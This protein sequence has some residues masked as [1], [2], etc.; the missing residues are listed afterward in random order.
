MKTISDILQYMLSQGDVLRAVYAVA[1]ALLIM[2]LWKLRL[3]G[4]DVVKLVRRYVLRVSWGNAWKLV[5]LT[6]IIW[7]A[8]GPFVSALQYVEQRWLRPVYVN[9]YH[10]FDA[11]VLTKMY[12]TEIAEHVTPLQL[13]TIRWWTKRT[14]TRIGCTPLE[15]YETAYFE[16]GG[17][18]FN[19][20]NPIAAGWI[21]FTTNGIKSH[22]VTLSQV[23]AACKARYV[24]PIMRLTDEYLYRR[25]QN[26]GKPLVTRMDVYMAIFSPAFIGCR[27]PEQVIYQGRDNPAYYKNDGLDGWKVVDEKIVQGEKD[28]RIRYGE[29]ELCVERKNARLRAQYLKN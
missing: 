20:K 26:S 23:Q 1:L 4:W 10:Y 29:I 12:E 19:L 18:P 2:Q 25:Q 7:G 6:L 8:A 15:I 22:G 13:D 9:Q 17:D 24:T 21:Q 14:A 11:Q 16:S 5:S 28:G 3:V 27:N